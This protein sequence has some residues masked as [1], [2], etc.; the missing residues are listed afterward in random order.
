MEEDVPGACHD[1]RC[2][3]ALCYCDPDILQSQAVPFKQ[4]PLHPLFTVLNETGGILP[5]RRLRPG[6]KIVLLPILSPIRAVEK[7]LRVPRPLVIVD[8]V[9]DR[10]K[11]P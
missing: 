5:D 4:G 1:A 6:N 11:V 8:P 2:L 7:L 9:G 10:L 3:P